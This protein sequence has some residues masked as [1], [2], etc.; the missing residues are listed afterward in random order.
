MSK[1]TCEESLAQIYLFLD[2]ELDEATRASIEIHLEHCSPCVAAFGLEMELRALVSRCC[3]EPVPRELRE[4]IAAALQ[5]MAQ[6]SQSDPG[7][8]GPPS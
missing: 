8:G 2:G 3:R 6:A 4:R 7:D 1:P 5:E